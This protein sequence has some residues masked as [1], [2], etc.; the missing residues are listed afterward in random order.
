M[1]EANKSICSVCGS[2]D[3]IKA[4]FD[5]GAVVVICKTC[6]VLRWYADNDVLSTW[7][8]KEK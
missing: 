4:T 6:G 1:V 7:Q 3:T 8:K 5:E 2:K